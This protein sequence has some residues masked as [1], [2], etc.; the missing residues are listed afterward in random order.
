MV[1]MEAHP[2]QAYRELY[3]TAQRLQFRY[4]TSRVGDAAAEVLFLAYE[5]EAEEAG[6]NEEDDFAA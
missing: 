2:E 6:E 1:T 4:P 3:E 5:R